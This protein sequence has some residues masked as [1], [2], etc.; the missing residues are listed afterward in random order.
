MSENYDRVFDCL[1]DSELIER[2]N[3]WCEKE[4]YWDDRIFDNDEYNVN[5]LVGEET[6]PYQAM[7]DM[8]NTS[9]NSTDDYVFVNGRGFVESF[10][11]VQEYVSDF[12]EAL[13]EID[14]A[15]EAEGYYED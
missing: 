7:R 1:S 14:K 13:A 2:F 12:P 4:Q 10:N 15:L 6:S 5:M 9:W 8:E 3:A 11:N